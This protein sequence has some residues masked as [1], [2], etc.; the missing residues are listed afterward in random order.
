MSSPKVERTHHEMQG[1]AGSY[2]TQDKAQSTSRDPVSNT[3]QKTT[4]TQTTYRTPDTQQLISNV[5][6][7]NLSVVVPVVL[8]VVLAL[9]LLSY[10]GAFTWH[11]E[12]KTWKD[13]V[14]EGVQNVRDG[15]NEG[16]SGYYEAAKDYVAD[17]AVRGQGLAHEKIGET[18]EYLKSAANVAQEKAKSAAEIAHEKVKGAAGAAH[19]KAKNAADIAHDKAKMHAS[20]ASDYAYDKANE[21]GAKASKV[22]HD[23]HAKANDAYES[24]TDPNILHRAAEYIHDKADAILNR[25]KTM[26]AEATEELLHQKNLASENARH[27]MAETKLKGDEKYDSLKEGANDLKRNVKS[28]VGL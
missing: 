17:A 15:M 9:I 2:V 18:S 19:E 16:L 4:R 6:K 26:S 21:A 28:K 3:T 23:A 13:T 7:M 1:P 5:S 12:P 24:A 14:S 27:Y 11:K 8:A 25:G 22:Y 20:R 10:R